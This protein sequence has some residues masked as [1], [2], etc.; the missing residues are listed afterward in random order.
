MMACHMHT[1]IFTTFFV[2]N[3][4]LQTERFFTRPAIN[5][6]PTCQQSNGPLGKSLT[7]VAPRQA[8][9]SVVGQKRVA[10]TR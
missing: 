9:G 8:V 6:V 5:L 4:Q 10:L 3:E 2:N 7:S 1:L